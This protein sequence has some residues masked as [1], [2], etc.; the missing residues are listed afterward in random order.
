MLVGLSPIKTPKAL[1]TKR[2]KGALETAL[3]ISEG[4]GM[5]PLHVDVL[6]VPGRKM[7]CKGVSRTSAAVFAPW[8]WL[9][10]PAWR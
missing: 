9:C 1:P 10:L 6:S 5:G 2:L 7:S 4:E 3:E 8:L